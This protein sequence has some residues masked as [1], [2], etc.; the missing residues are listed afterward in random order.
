VGELIEKHCSKCAQ[1]KPLEAFYRKT[2]NKK[3]GHTPH[4]KEC[5]AEYQRQT[6]EKAAERARAW[7]KRNREHLNAYN[8]EWNKNRDEESKE[9]KRQYNRELARKYHREAIQAYGGFCTCCGETEMSFLQ[10]DHINNDGAEHRKS[11]NGVQL[12]PWLKRRGYPE[13]F[14]VLCVNCNFAK[15]TNGGTCPHQ[16]VMNQVIR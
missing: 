15:H 9:R 2:R 3:D 6:K 12:A 1:T 5:M 8:R 13:G 10:I 16:T 7:K 4:C 11:I 14:Q